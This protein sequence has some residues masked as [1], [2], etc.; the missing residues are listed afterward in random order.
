[1]YVTPVDQKKLIQSA[2]DGMLT[3]LDPHSGYLDPDDF[4]DLEDQTRGQYGGLGIEVTS[5]D[6]AVKIISPMDDTPAARA[7]LQSGDYITAMDGGSLI[8]LPLSDAV[9]K[10]RGDIGKP[11]TLTVVRKDK[12]PF[13]VKL[14]RESINVKSAKGHM[15]GDYGF[16]RISSFDEQT[17][18]Q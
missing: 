1:Q 16:L 8:G 18:D 17:T 13:E 11:I 2:M 9:K 10:M 15:E 14:V 7:G 3:S 4:R 12:D 5:E 6:G